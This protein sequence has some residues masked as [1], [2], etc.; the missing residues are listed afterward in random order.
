MQGDR[1]IMFTPTSKYSVQPIGAFLIQMYTFLGIR[2][3]PVS[4]EEAAFV[5]EVKT[6]AAPAP[7]P[8]PF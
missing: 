1:G 8:F 2:Q 6:E 7:M 4:L 3:Q 5:K